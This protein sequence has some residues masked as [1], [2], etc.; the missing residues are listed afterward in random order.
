MGRQEEAI[1]IQ[2]PAR[3]ELKTVG[4]TNVYEARNITFE[5]RIAI[6][7]LVVDYTYIQDILVDHIEMF[8]RQGTLPFRGA[9]RQIIIVIAEERYNKPSSSIIIIVDHIEMFMRQGT[10]P[11]RSATTNH[12]HHFHL[13]RRQKISR[14]FKIKVNLQQFVPTKALFGCQMKFT[15]QNQI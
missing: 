12:H 4:E 1:T 7:I 2:T 9:L 8:M 14:V 11:S 5:Q 13:S 10:L 15:C 6:I 3:P